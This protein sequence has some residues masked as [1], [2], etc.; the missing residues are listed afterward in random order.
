MWLCYELPF[1]CSNIM[2]IYCV[3]C[4]TIILWSYKF[5]DS[6][7]DLKLLHKEDMNI[8]CWKAC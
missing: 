5:Y 2:I 4:R 1:T 7:I 6:Q 8:P 3:G